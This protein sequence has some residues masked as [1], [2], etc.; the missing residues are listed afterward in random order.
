M[1][2][3]ILYPSRDEE[4]PLIDDYDCVVIDECHR[5]YTLDREMSDAE[6]GFRN[7]E[8]Y[9]SQYRRVLDYFDAVK[10]GLTATPALHTTEIFGD[11]VFQYSYREAVV[12]G[13]LVDHEPPIRITTQ[14][15]R[16]GIRWRAGEN[17]NVL[18]PRTQQLDLIHLPDELNF[19]VDE[20]NRAV[21]TEN[22]NRVVCEELARQID[23]N[24]DGK[25][26]VFC[27][28]D[29]HADTVVKQLKKA[30]DDQY[31]AVD[32]DAVAKITGTSDKPLQLIRRFKN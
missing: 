31:G 6:L 29:Q 21:I 5:G 28:N 25:T 10:I 3:R 13:W 20:F 22:F 30:L 12:D 14:L 23:P 11:P 1:L 24:D 9:V 18:D 32:D 15:A 27:A 4:Q 16:R 8:D 19:D 7:Q 2:K 26:L 17:V